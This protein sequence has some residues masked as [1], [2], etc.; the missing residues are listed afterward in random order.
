[1]FSGNV[2]KFSDDVPAQITVLCR[3]LWARSQR[4]LGVAL[5]GATGLRGIWTKGLFFFK[6][7]EKK[8]KGQGCLGL[9]LWWGARRSLFVGS[10]LFSGGGRA[11]ALR[12]SVAWM[13]L[14]DKDQK[15]IFVWMQSILSILRS[16]NINYFLV[17]FVRPF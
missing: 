7:R 9:V 4:F 1:M 15:I 16:K 5:T 14:P 11:I 2:S 6:E 3:Q 12:F 17:P 13:Q 10:C 8:D